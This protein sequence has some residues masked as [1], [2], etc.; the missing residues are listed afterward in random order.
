MPKLSIGVPVFNGQ[1]FL[2][3]LLDSLL[4]QTFGDFEIVICDNA[5]SDQTSGICCEYERRDSRIRYIRNSRNLGAIANFNRVFELSTAP[6]FKWAAHDDLHHTA[7]LETCVGLLERNPEVVLAHTATAFIG[8]KSEILQFDQ[9]TG[10]FFDPGTGRRYWPDIPSI[11]DHPVAIS[12]FWQV[13]TRARWGTHMFGVV[14]RE[15]LQRTSLLPNFVGSDRAMLAE[16]AL[17]GRFRCANER[18]FLKRF[19]PNVS[20]ALD[21]KELRGFL[22][23]DGKR[24]SRRLRQIQ[25]YFGAPIGKPIGIMS[26]LA[27]L[28]LVAAHSAKIT[29]Q[30]L[31]QGDPRMA[32]HGYGWQGVLT[33]GERRKPHD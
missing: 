32:A 8:E 12:R 4:A 28:L 3:E 30:S 33:A 14:R 22:S 16:L 15:I 18:L 23:T 7:Y 21:L 31:G 26:K 29:V 1:Q 5:S 27:C 17:L 19:H 9:E 10:S 13:L 20:A 24:Y 25:A 11:G 6:L 2:P